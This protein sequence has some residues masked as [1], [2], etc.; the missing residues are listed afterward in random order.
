MIERWGPGRRWRRW[1][2]RG[3]ISGRGGTHGALLLELLLS[4]YL[5]PL[6]RNVGWGGI[7]RNTH[8]R[9][10]GGVD[11][12]GWDD[13]EWDGRFG[14]H[15]A[16]DTHLSARGGKPDD[17]FCGEDRQL[18]RKHPV[19]ALGGDR[20]TGVGSASRHGHEEIRFC[21]FPALENLLFGV[22]VP[23]CPWKE[24]VKEREKQTTPQGGMGGRHAATTHGF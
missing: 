11:G 21:R 5:E 18:L 20:G 2:W 14:E 3:A 9:G 6:L 19:C 13:G 23:L 22:H 10:R 15:L 12:W 8:R 1:R 24:K 7:S 16:L 4:E 17:G